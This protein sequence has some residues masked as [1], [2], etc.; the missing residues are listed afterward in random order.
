MTPEQVKYN[1]DLIL[2]EKSMVVPFAKQV[3]IKESGSLP[4]GMEAPTTQA[5]NAWMKQMCMALQAQCMTRVEAALEAETTSA[6]E[7]YKQRFIAEY[8]QEE[9]DWCLGGR[10]WPPEPEPA[11]FCGTS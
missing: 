5:D 10:V 1:R 3:E 6:C 4:I 2:Q 7:D 9:W 8:G 11:T